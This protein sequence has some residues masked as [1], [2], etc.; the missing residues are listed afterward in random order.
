[1]IKEEVYN[2]PNKPLIVGKNDENNQSLVPGYGELTADDLSR[3]IFNRFSQKIGVES[4]N[5]KIKII[6]EVDKRIYGES[7]TSRS[8]YFSVRLPEQ[9]L[10][11][12]PAVRLCF[13]LVVLFRR[14]SQHLQHGF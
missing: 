9:P 12:R 5:N 11:L 6:S 8:M 7:L 10:M 2:Y 13:S 1:M 14:Q 3:I 4:D